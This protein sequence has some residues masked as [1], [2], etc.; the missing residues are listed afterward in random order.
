MYIGFVIQ[1]L[2]SKIL[3]PKLLTGIY[4]YIYT[5]IITYIIHIIYIYLHTIIFIIHIRY[6][7]V[8]GKTYN[9]TCA[10]SKDS[11]QPALLY[12]LIRAFPD[13]MYLLQ[14]P[15]YPKRDKQE[16]L[17]YWVDVQ[18]DLSLLVTQILLLVLSCTGSYMFSLTRGYWVCETI[19][20]CPHLFSV[21]CQL[22]QKKTKM[23]IRYFF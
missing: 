22:H 18:A 4:I 23:Q 1:A 3:V 10:T 2:S 11:D 14:P 8:H 6:E 17:P 7:S 21:L 16:P 15:G 19:C 9:K 13:C 20:F 12:S 5:H